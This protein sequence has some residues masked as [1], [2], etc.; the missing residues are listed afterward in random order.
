MGEG[1]K[2]VKKGTRE[3]E[4]DGR[5]GGRSGGEERRDEE[6]MTHMWSPTFDLQ[7]LKLPYPHCQSLGP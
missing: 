7:Y 5:E 4:K 1:E 6:A 2:E 3:G